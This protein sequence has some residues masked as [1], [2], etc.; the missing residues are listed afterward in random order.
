MDPTEKLPARRRKLPTAIDNRY[1]AGH[2]LLPEDGERPAN[3]N[4]LE[5]SVRRMK[6]EHSVH[7]QAG[8]RNGYRF[9]RRL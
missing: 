8:V 4:G 1:P 3:R 5:H 2:L 9:S 7:L 6:N